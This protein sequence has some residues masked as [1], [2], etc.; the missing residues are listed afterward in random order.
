MSLHNNLLAITCNMDRG[1]LAL[2]ILENVVPDR[3]LSIEDNANLLQ[4]D[5]GRF[6]VGEIHDG[7]VDGY[8]HVADDVVFPAH[9]LEGHRVG[10][11][12]TGDGGLH[13]QVLCADEL[14]ADVVAHA[15]D[16]ISGQNTVP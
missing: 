3:P 13:K 16:S 5:L 9:I 15:F 1:R 10:V 2:L 4:G 14:G 12:E 8:D 11:V 6:R 7:N